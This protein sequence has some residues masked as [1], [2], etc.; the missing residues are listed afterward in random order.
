MASLAAAVAAFLLVSGL[1]GV[2]IGIV[3]IVG[4]P[5][6]AR[7]LEPKSVRESRMRMTAQ[8]P[9][10]ADLLAATMAAG[11][12]TGVALLAVCEAIDDPASSVLRPVAASLQLGADTGGAWQPL[13][14]DE[15]L[16]AIAAAMIRS[17]E[18]GAPLSAILARIADDLRRE[19]QVSVEV[20]AR[21]AGVR[22]VL[23][24]AACFLPAFVLLGIVPVVA[25]LGGG[26]LA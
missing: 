23:P 22:A 9:L 11:S 4:I 18:S 2:V 21:A 24:L 10:V 6:I 15:S 17:A 7:Q 20:A 16:G 19:H 25:A 26:L 3:C 5:R 14:T 12:P 13:V 1:P 8:A